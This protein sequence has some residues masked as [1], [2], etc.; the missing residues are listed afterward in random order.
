MAYTSWFNKIRA[1]F[2]VKGVP[3]EGVLHKGRPDKVESGAWKKG[4]CKFCGS[5]NGFVFISNM[6]PQVKVLFCQ[7]CGKYHRYYEEATSRPK[8]D[9]RCWATTSR[10]VRC[11]NKANADG[12]CTLHSPK[13]R[14]QV[15]DNQDGSA[16]IHGKTV[17]LGF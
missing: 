11:K 17:G 7:R 8:V 14:P 3:V 15:V 2:S 4:K 6:D 16:S 10:G 12:F 9:G 13:E 1:G 5:P